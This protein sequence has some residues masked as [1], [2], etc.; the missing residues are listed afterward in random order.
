M[1]KKIFQSVVL[2]GSAALTGAAEAIEVNVEGENTETQSAVITD[3][4]LK[5]GTGTYI[6]NQNNTYT[7]GT[8]IQAG[9][10][11]MGDGTT[12]GLTYLGT[13]GTVTIRNG[14]TLTMNTAAA[15]TIVLFSGKTFKVEDGGKISVSK[16]D[17]RLA[18]SSIK[19][20]SGRSV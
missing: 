18:G 11:Q 3:S 8:V 5:T 16:G 19:L 4:L 1:W 17:L 20:D 6:L 13:G 12:A 2:F 10:L 14:A 15:N 7:G 9:T